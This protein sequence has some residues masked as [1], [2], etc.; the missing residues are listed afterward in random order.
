MVQEE[1]RKTNILDLIFTNSPTIRGTEIVPNSNEISDH[2]MVISTF[3]KVQKT[4]NGDE[5]PVDS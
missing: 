1:T 5:E 2:N 4:E 3:L